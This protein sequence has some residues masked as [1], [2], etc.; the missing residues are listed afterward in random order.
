MYKKGRHIHFMGI[1]GIGMSGIAA[2]LRQKGYIVS[3]CDLS[4]KSSILSWLK[5][6]GCKIFSGHDCEHINEADV[7]V[8]SSA[9]DINH[10]EVEAAL[11][12]GIPVIPRAIM[13]AELMRMKYGIAI[14]GSH[15]KTTTTSM[16]SHIFTEADLDP[17]IVIG[18]VLKNL[19]T[20]AKLGNGDLLVAEAD[21]SDRSLLYLNPS[22]AIVTNIDAEH[23]DTYKDLSDV[24]ETFKN[25]LARLPFYGKAFV[26]IDDPNIR[27]IL[28][29]PHIQTVRYG[30]GPSANIRG[31]I[32]EVGHSYSNFNVYEKNSLLGSVCIHMPGEHNVLNALAAIALS[33]EFDISFSSIKKALEGFK[34]VE[35]RFEYKGSFNGAEVFDDYGH[36]P[37]EI[38][39]TL[40]VARRKAKNKLHVVF[41]PHRYTRTQKLWD[42]FVQTLAFSD[43]DTLFLADIYPASEDPIDNITS[44][45][46]TR[47]IKGQNPNIKIFHVSCYDK[48]A[49][50]VKGML[51]EGDLLITIGAGKAN[52][53]GSIILDQ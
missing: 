38:Q 23:L 19:S 34:G 22:V 6:L 28:P 50:Q 8:Y 2:I 51:N 4:E 12:K 9:V 27:S 53:V 48:I 46:L 33:L 26:C 44:E 1:G 40:N 39:K 41:Q 43:I 24:K 45:R 3:G 37:T 30:L 47:E 21:E 35:R 7:L 42:E 25:F 5:K 16:I 32:T 11:K 49:C 14:S 15:G 10:V 52:R 18:G 13:L 31:E 20:H 17:T 29:L 36:H